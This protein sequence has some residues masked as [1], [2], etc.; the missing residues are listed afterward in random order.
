MEERV[1]FGSQFQRLQYKIT[2][3]GY[4]VPLQRQNIIIGML[5]ADPAV[6]SEINI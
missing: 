1:I 4:F 6:Q 2:C 3:Q 5:T